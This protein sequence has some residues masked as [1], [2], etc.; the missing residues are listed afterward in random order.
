MDQTRKD[1]HNMSR[2][3][4]TSDNARKKWGKKNNR[5]RSKQRKKELTQIYLDNERF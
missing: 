2:I 1:R 5:N 3:G 4:N